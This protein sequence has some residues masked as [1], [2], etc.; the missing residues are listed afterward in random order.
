MSNNGNRFSTLCLGSRRMLVVLAR[1][2]PSYFLDF[3]RLAYGIENTDEYS[4]EPEF[5]V[6]IS[7]YVKEGFNDIVIRSP[8]E[9]YFILEFQSTTPRDLVSRMQR[10]YE[11]FRTMI[12]KPGRPIEG[13]PKVRLLV[14]LKKNL[15]EH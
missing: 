2:H 5:P 1:R 13:T 7:P 4:V 15:P 9:G 11:A 10:Y 3:I 8:D 12:L 14:I 6:S